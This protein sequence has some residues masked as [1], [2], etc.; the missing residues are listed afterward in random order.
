MQS[1]ESIY[2]LENSTRISRVN[3]SVFTHYT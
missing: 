2:L 3:T 1:K